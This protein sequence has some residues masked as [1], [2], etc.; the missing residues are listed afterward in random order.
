MRE[1]APSAPLSFVLA[2]GDRV[3]L[4][5][6]SGVGK[7][8]LLTRLAGLDVGVATEGTI[9]INGNDPNHHRGVA[10]YVLQD[11]LTQAVM[12]RVGD[13]IAFGLENIGVD[14]AA[15]PERIRHA[16]AS[17][18]LDVPLDALTDQLSGGQRQRLALAGVLVMR[19]SLLLLD[20][21][22]ANLD[23]AG[24]YLIRDAV[25][26]AVRDRHITLVVVD[27]N[28]GFWADVVD[29]EIVMGD[30]GDAKTRGAHRVHSRTRETPAREKPVAPPKPPTLA[31][32]TNLAVGYPRSPR[33]QNNLN[34]EIVAGRILTVTGPNGAGKSALA[35]TLAGLIP[36]HAG[37]LQLDRHRVPVGLVFQTPEH[38]F[39]GSTVRDDVTAGMRG[40]R[41]DREARVQAT[42][43]EFQLTHLA[44]HNPF[45]LSGGE[46]RRLS[47]AD[48][49]A[50]LPHDRS[51]ILVVDEPTTGLDHE[52]WIDLVESLRAKASEGHAIVVITHDQQLICAISDERLELSS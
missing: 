37:E 27:H 23:P 47:I 49:V 44:A 40:P 10:G 26:E 29:R 16:L 22:T 7:S 2:P 24:A 45:S 17:V 12:P 35:L 38:Q 6:R 14:P 42:L 20:E 52:S 9:R 41:R 3:L 28:D 31:R 39:I 18:G 33:A 30:E 32:A 4:R 11:P 25:R 19:P 43:D 36:A 21:P 15:M 50:T 8:T 1:G 51:A 34:F 13:D 48:I 46:K 5:G